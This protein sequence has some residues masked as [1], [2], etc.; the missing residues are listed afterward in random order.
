MIFFG[1]SF[2][3]SGSDRLRNLVMLQ[4]LKW[5]FINLLLL[6]AVDPYIDI[7]VFFLLSEPKRLNFLH[8]ILIRYF[9]NN[10]NLFVLLSLKL[11]RRR[12]IQLLDDCVF[13]LVK[14]FTILF[15]RFLNTIF[16]IYFRLKI[17]LSWTFASIYAIVFLCFS[18]EDQFLEIFPVGLMCLLIFGL[19]WWKYRFNLLI[20]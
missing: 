18:L 15:L 9:M 1:A 14:I 11:W 20:G 16:S 6:W 7:L 8:P 13:K 19:T 12:F 3:K 4:F 17:F 5:N 10:F 2:L